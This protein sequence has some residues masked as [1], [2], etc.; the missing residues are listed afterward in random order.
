MGDQNF[1]RFQSLAGFFVACNWSSSCGR[2]S[3]PS[4]F[5]PWRVFSWLA[6]PRW[7]GGGGAPCG[8]S[9]PGGFFRG[10]QLSFSLPSQAIGRSFNPWRVFSWLA[11][12]PSLYLISSSSLFQ[13]LA[14]F[15]VACNC[16]RL[17]WPAVSVVVS[18]PGGFF[19]GLQ[20][21]C[22][23]LS[24]HD[25]TCFN[26]WRV[27]SWL[28]TLLTCQ[29]SFL[30]PVSIP[31]GF[32]RGLQP[33]KWHD[34][35]MPCSFSFNPWRVF[36]WLATSELDYK[37][38]HPRLFQSL[39]G[40]FVACNKMID[41]D[42]YLYD[43]QVSIPGGFFRGLQRK[44]TIDD[45]AINAGFNPWRVF[46]WLATSPTRSLL[47]SSGRFQSLAG[48]FVACNSMSKFMVKVK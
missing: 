7:G 17:S 19:R 33:T 35:I 24:S 2:L 34:T 37:V 4:G 14:G 11:T 38:L 9:I 20:R 6:T 30:F 13:S 16:Q 29:E 31:G 18:I 22:S 40:F 27:F 32:F 48:F 23:C 44:L 46:S 1:E 39:A 25:F 12:R 45:M 26:P 15:F 42:N 43:L 41:C 10:L 47:W 5:N 3:Q 21:Y 8:V 28:A 36:S